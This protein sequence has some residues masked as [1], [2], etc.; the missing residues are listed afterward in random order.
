[1]LVPYYRLFS[2]SY[3][4]HPNY[5]SHFPP[6]YPPWST[7]YTFPK[8]SDADRRNSRHQTPGPGQYN[9]PTGVGKQV[10]S[11]KKSYIGFG[12][13]TS[14]RPDLLLQ[15]TAEVGPGEYPIPGSTGER[16]VDSRKLNRNGVPFTKAARMGKPCNLEDV[17][18]GPGNYEL[19]AAICGRQ[20][21]A[22][23]YR[24]APSVTLSGREKFG[25]P[26]GW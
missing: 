23:P 9:L 5:M 17:P 21:A 19:P 11:T 13:G 16:Q 10:L 1:M 15:S 14:N 8:D 24:S 22:S 12:F 20:G 26:F 3:H 18:P 7:Q 2:S 6:H 4:V 25:S